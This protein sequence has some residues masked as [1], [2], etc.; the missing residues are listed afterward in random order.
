[1][2]G[3][4]DADRRSNTLRHDGHVSKPPTLPDADA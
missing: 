1:M 4:G 3:N 2:A